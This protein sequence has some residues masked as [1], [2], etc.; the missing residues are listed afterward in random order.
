MVSSSFT[1][2]FFNRGCKGKRIDAPI[3][4]WGGDM[5]GDT[6]GRDDRTTGGARGEG[7][8]GGGGGG[9]GWVGWGHYSSIV[10]LSSRITRVMA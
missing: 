4:V 5:M 3:I 8:V 6:E 10:C 9:E 1:A 7:R 2:F